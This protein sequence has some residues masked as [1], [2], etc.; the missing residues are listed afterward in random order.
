MRRLILFALT[1]GL[2]SACAIGPDYQRD[3]PPLR[4]RLAAGRRGAQA[5]A[6]RALVD[7][8]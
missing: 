4:R 7:T 2:L 6:G 3:T 5:G 8:L 1:S